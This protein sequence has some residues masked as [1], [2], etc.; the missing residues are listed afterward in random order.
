MNNNEIL[1][2]LSYME[3]SQLTKTEVMKAIF[4]LLGKERGAVVYLADE[5]GICPQAVSRWKSDKPIPRMHRLHLELKRPDVI[6]LLENKASV[7]D[8]QST[9]EESVA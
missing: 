6:E 2:T 7:P 9:P 1:V 4:R 3:A 5:L 8:T